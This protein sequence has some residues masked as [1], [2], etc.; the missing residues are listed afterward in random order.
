MTERLSR[1]LLQLSE[2]GDPA[3]LW[4]RLAKP[5]LGREFDRLLSRGVLVEEAP[6]EEWDVCSDCECGHECR[7]IQTIDGKLIA[8]CPYDHRSDTILEP[9]DLR[10]FRI[11]SSA[12]VNELAHASGFE[13]APSEIMP[14]VWRLG[15]VP[16]GRVA[17]LGLSRAAVTA[18]GLVGTI[19]LTDRATPITIVC[20]KLDAASLIRLAE[21]DVFV[22]PL[23]DCLVATPGGLGSVIDRSRMEPVMMR[24]P[25]LV[26]RRISR[27]VE[28]DGV[29]KDLSEQTLKL[30][31]LLIERIG[32]DK[33]YAAARDVE[34]CIWG[35]HINLVVR[36][37]RDVVRE[38]REDL[39]RGA[40]NPE[41][42]RALIGNRRGQG[43]LLELP[44]SEIRLL[45]G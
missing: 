11:F 2:A 14:G 1:L 4:G 33:P 31:V 12:L 44:A 5:F 7:T 8:A 9:E 26:V 25:R 6:A 35:Q 32:T 13:N 45:E 29:R 16:S 23:A 10:S 36:Q 30:L 38:L 15:Q 37:A 42:A 19:R 21:A 20:P 18:P 28:L 27:I 17:F 3:I 34:E 24:A 40:A 41:A 43:W 39:E 22:V